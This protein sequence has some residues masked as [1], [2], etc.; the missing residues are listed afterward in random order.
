MQSL[1]SSINDI[2]QEFF[3]A[4]SDQFP[5]ASVSDEFF[6]FPQ[7]KPQKRDWSHWDTFSESAVN[8]FARKLLEY[9]NGLDRVGS[10]H[11][12]TAQQNLDD[13]VDRSFLTQTITTLREQLTEVRSWEKQPTFHLTIACLGVAEA[14]ES[15]DPSAAAARMET[16]PSFIDRARYSLK[17]MPTLY[18]DL[19]LTM[20]A[21]TK[22]YLISL[23]PRIP[24]VKAA[25]SAL[26]AFERFLQKVKTQADFRMPGSLVEK[27]IY[28]HLGCRLHI[29]QIDSL[30]D[31]EIHDMQAFLEKH[32]TAIAGD[33]PWERVMDKIPLPTV[34]SGGLVA[35]YDDQV[36]QLAEHCLS[37]GFLFENALSACPVQVRPVPSF[38]SAIRTASSYSVQPDQ[39]PTGGIFYVI[40]ADEPGEAHKAY[41]KEYRILS[42]HET[43]PGHHFLD[44]NRLRL[45]QALRRCIEKPIFYEGW[46]CFAE[47][48]MQLTGYL[49]NAH[50]PMLLARRRL[51]RAMRGKVDLGLQTGT[52]DFSEAIEYL[53]KTGIQEGDA[54]AVVRKYPLNPGY[55]L[56]YTLGF[57]RFSKLYNTHGRG[58]LK[59][60]VR[61]AVSHGE[62][63]FDDLER[64]LA[65]KIQAGKFGKKQD[66]LSRKH[67]RSK[68][69]KR[70]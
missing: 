13:Q 32:A 52:M 37:C 63:D 68:T 10:R 9:E 20:L 35:M 12:T 30:L 31:S 36:R 44:S 45:S 29:P 33:L 3:A 25:L 48:L 17:R 41:Q 23:I 69:R 53:M 43:Y 2:C 46:A 61:Q 24:G 6:Y 21:A 39:P 40:N 47:K 58:N 27:I 55:Q 34:P 38:L 28:H 59:A 64:I 8:S 1:S 51:W 70:P 54:A 67:E 5:I 49:D 66:L 11:E 42:A 62:I 15:D 19:G 65:L 56:C 16:L 14:L 22:R 4:S 60:F 57:I 50:D 7:V 26:D 18:R